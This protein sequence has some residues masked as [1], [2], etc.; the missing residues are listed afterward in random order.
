MQ[1]RA[2]IPRHH[3]RVTAGLHRARLDQ[4]YTIK[5]LAAKVGVHPQHLSRVERGMKRPGANLLV[6]LSAALEAPLDAISTTDATPA[7][8]ASPQPAK[9]A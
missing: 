7:R 9:A 8:E 2:A 1:D 4:G 5:A 3:R 6:R